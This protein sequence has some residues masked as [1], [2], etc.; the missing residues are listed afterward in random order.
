MPDVSTQ[1][2]PDY[3][4]PVADHGG[5]QS[6]RVQRYDRSDSYGRWGEFLR[7][8]TSWSRAQDSSNYTQPTRASEVAVEPGS[9]L[10]VALAEELTAA[11]TGEPNALRPVLDFVEAYERGDWT[12][13]AALCAHL[14]IDPTRV[15]H[16]Y[17]IAVAYAAQGFVS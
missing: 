4:G 12:R 1:I 16:L 6:A 14:Q 11:L 3:R 17:R 15:A 2:S 7:R 5:N 10:T 8:K 9:V 13:S